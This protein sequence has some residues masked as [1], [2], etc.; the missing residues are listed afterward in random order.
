MKSFHTVKIDKFH[1]FGNGIFHLTVF[2]KSNSHAALVDMLYTKGADGNWKF[3]YETSTCLDNDERADIEEWLLENHLGKEEV[4]EYWIDAS[5]RMRIQSTSYDNA[6]V[7]LYKKL[8][9]IGAEQYRETY[10]VEV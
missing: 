2:A 6:V 1:N 10:R 5:I 4:K 3:Q 7:E 9:E 8:D